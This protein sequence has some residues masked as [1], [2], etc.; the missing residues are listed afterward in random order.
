MQSQLAA[1]RE[2]VTIPLKP[3]LHFSI[4]ARDALHLA[5]MVLRRKVGDAALKNDGYQTDS[6]FLRGFVV[7]LCIATVGVVAFAVPLSFAQNQSSAPR[8]SAHIVSQIRTE[9]GLPFPRWCY[10]SSPAFVFVSGRALLKADVAG[11]IVQRVPLPAPMHIDRCSNDG[12]T[13]SLLDAS[14]EYLFI[15]DTRAANLSQY[16]ISA[17]PLFTGRPGSS[18]MSPDGRTFTLPR[19]PVLVSGPDV[20]HNKHIIHVS[21]P[22]VFWT[23]NF[24]FVRDA[25]KLFSAYFA[26]QT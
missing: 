25:S 9:A 17:G 23:H 18:L 16:R 6:T 22:D 7:R 10:D 12:S 19:P 11:Q 1:L 13:V 26:F 3:P 4:A 21:N 5:S 15:V 20:L 14:H 24:V 8:S 2:P